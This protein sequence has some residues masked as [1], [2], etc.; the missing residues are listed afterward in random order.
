MKRYAKNT[1]SFFFIVVI[2]VVILFCLPFLRQINRLSNND[3]WFSAFAFN[4]FSRM[5]LI[6][7]HQLPLW[8]P[9]SGGGTPII[10]HPYQG[11]INPLFI[12]VLL[13]GEVAG[14]KI[15]TL[16]IYLAGATGMYYLA[17]FCLKFNPAAALFSALVF[18]LSGYL[19]SF[20]NDGN[21]FHIYIFLLPWPVAFFLKSVNSKGKIRYMALCSF[22]L[23]LIL[24]QAGF[25][26]IVASGI[27][28]LVCLFNSFTFNLSRPILS[29]KLPY[30]KNFL[31]VILLT[32]LM[33]AVKLIPMVEF[34]DSRVSP[35][36]SEYEDDY[37]Q[38]SQVAVRMHSPL[39]WQRMF[40]FLFIRHSKEVLPS[41]YVGFIPVIFALLAAVFKPGKNLVWIVLFTVFLFLSMGPLAP[42]DLFKLLWLLHPYFHFIV[43]HSK[44]FSIGIIFAISILS[45]SFISYLLQKEIAFN[46]VKH[47][48]TL[49]LLALSLSSL[50]DLFNTNVYFHKDIFTQPPPDLRRQ[51]DFFH[52]FLK[53][54][55][56]R[57]PICKQQY[58]YLL[59]NVGLINWHSN[60]LLRE[61]AAPKY[62]ATVSDWQDFENMQLSP[63]YKGEFYFLNNKNKVRCDLF[64]PGRISLYVETE[65][66]DYLI[67]NQNYNPGWRSTSGYTQDYGG[68]LSIRLDK[69]G[70]QNIVLHYVPREF[71]IGLGLS[72]LMI[73]CLS[74][75]V[76]RDEVKR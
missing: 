42:V 43:K 24:L 7:H 52:I 56:G 44:Y 75:L 63:E 53:G 65:E 68:L 62:Y 14:L 5:S 66:P 59:Q 4:H 76:I 54:I 61:S 29:I 31:I 39:N 27:I 64:S 22:M 30:L 19:P 9:Y 2:V 35:V 51:E 37:R 20:L 41:C 6:R 71:W 33:C 49:F 73:I 70:K 40:S 25:F 13:F 8:S 67:I 26:F 18:I 45:G 48:I 34:I 36:H 47:L 17:R 58:F 55:P 16:I 10:G 15:I 21:Y 46:P 23:S 32:L 69:P 72:S 11:F 50:V 60:I 57:D 3:E 28:F 1:D 38:I 74:A 12:F